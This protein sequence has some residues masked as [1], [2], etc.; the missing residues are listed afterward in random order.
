MGDQGAQE[1][2][3]EPEQMEEVRIETGE[4]ERE[5]SLAVEPHKGN[6]VLTPLNPPT[7]HPTLAS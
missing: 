5:E 7:L 4:L 2:S 1:G 3:Y 6:T